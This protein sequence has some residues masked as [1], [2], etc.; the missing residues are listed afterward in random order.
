MSLAK[1]LEY[2]NLTEFL[3]G[4]GFLSPSSSR[5]SST[6]SSASTSRSASPVREKENEISEFMEEVKKDLEYLKNNTKEDIIDFGN[7]QVN[8]FQQSIEP[9]KTKA[10]E[11]LNSY[12]EKIIEDIVLYFRAK[13]EEDIRKQYE[14]WEKSGN[15]PDTDMMPGFYVDSV[16]DTTVFNPQYS[17]RIQFYKPYYTEER[18]RRIDHFIVLKGNHLEFSLDYFKLMA[19]MIIV[20][21]LNFHVK[22]L[23]EKYGIISFE[24]W[25]QR[26]DPYGFIEPQSE[27]LTTYEGNLKYNVTAKVS[28]FMEFHEERKQHK[29]LTI[30]QIDQIFPANQ[31]N[32]KENAGFFANFRLWK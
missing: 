23:L 7:E 6:S 16:K 5:S 1:F 18:L 21:H 24:T 30:A 20:Y 31:I 27:N 3:K 19:E 32:Q 25:L 8:Y 29:T 11:T 4:D 14:T 10:H 22:T 28:K 26:I 13:T 17:I 12:K 2:G 9:L 15:S